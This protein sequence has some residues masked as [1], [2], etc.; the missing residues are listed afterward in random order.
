VPGAKIDALS[1]GLR[2]RFGSI[3]HRDES[4]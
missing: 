1:L 2:F 3:V 4:P